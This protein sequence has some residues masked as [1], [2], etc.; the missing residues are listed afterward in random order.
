MYPPVFEAVNVP[1]VQAL[2]R[3]L[4]GPLRVYEFGMAPQEVSYPYAVWRM[5]AGAPGNYLGRRPDHDSAVVQID[6]YAKP[7]QGAPMAR[8]VALALRDAIEGHAYVTSWRGDSIDPDTKNFN[9]SFDC[10]FV[11]SR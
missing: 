11:V 7:S 4:K 1:A 10:S 6:V 3:A 5:A 9:V 8:A 2:L